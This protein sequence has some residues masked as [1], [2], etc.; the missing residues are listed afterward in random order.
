M[1]SLSVQPQNPSYNAA[2]HSHVE[3]VKL[4]NVH[5]EIKR[6]QEAVSELSLSE[7]PSLA[8]LKAS[9][10][11][12]PDLEKKLCS[13]YHR[14]VGILCPDGLLPKCPFYKIII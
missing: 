2:G 6:R 10:H 12:L 5:R 9:L 3:S 11:K 8:L 1:S 13:V 4:N 7:S 14:K